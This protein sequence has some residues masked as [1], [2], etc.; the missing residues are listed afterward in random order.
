[1]ALVGKVCSRGVWDESVPGIEFDKNGVSNYAH[2]FDRL[3]EAYPRGEKGKIAWEDKVEKMKRHGKGKKYDCIIGVSGGTDSCF[4]LHTAKSDYGLR[5]LAVNLDNGWNSD[6]AVKNIK[7]ITSKLSI[8][9]VT[10]VIDYEEI[11]DLMRVFMLGGIPWIDTATDLAIKAVM[12]KIA[13]EEGIKYI[14]RGNDFRSEGTQPIEWTGGDDRVLKFLHKK[15]GRTRLKTYPDYTLFNLLYFGFIKGIESIYPY[16]YLNYQKENAQA[17]LRENYEWEYYGGHHHENIF[18][19]FVMSYWLPVKFNIDKRKISLSAQ[20]LS[21]AIER[22]A[23]LKELESLPYNKDEIESSILY[24][25][26]KLDFQPDEFE[27]IMN[28]PNRSFLDYPSYYPLLIKYKILTNWVLKLVLN[29]KPMAMFQI[30]MRASK[31]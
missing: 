14:L 24:L 6:F 8:D 18:T 11:K 28:S 16:Y 22:E 15:Y 29:K 21:K 23:A 17:L 9:L 13:S 20:V 12:Y 31:R 2:L 10:Y 5:P 1:M 4:L 30:E 27:K 3:V 25:I 19:K 7:R 26:K